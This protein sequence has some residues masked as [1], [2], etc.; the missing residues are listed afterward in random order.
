MKTNKISFPTLMIIV[1]VASLLFSA[2][3]S[4]YR[5]ETVD[6][7]ATSDPTGE[8]EITPM[9]VVEEFYDWYISYPGHPLS[10]NAYQDHPAVSQEFIDKVEE[11]KSGILMAD[12]VLCAQDV[13]DNFTAGGGVISGDQAEVTVL[14]SWNT[15][16]NVQLKLNEDVW[17][18]VN[19]T[20]KR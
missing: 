6:N 19:I 7:L 5:N 9:Q 12:P 4:L 2:C 13:P 16:I 18:I 14:T 15:Q 20:C 3:A 17:K 11:L 10:E 8:Q 1:L